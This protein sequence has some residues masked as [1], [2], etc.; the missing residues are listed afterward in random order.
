MFGWTLTAPVE[1][2]PNLLA[3]WHVWFH[4]HTEGTQ[5]LRSKEKR[6]QLINKSAEN[7]F[8]WPT[9]KWT[10]VSSFIDQL[11]TLFSH[12]WIISLLT[13][14]VLGSASTGQG[15]HPRHCHHF[16]SFFLALNTFR[17]VL[18][19][20]WS[21]NWQVSGGSEASSWS[22]SHKVSRSTPGYFPRMGYQ[23]T[24]GY[25]QHFVILPWK[26]PSSHLHFCQ[27]RSAVRVTYLANEHNIMTWPGLIPRPLD[28]ESSVLTIC[29]PLK[30]MI[31]W[32]I[33]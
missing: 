23:P 22:L 10:F 25:F 14:S 5:P 4:H 1:D 2:H 13:V 8:K 17:G 12:Q 11:I 19:T 28:L 30:F 7:I 9:T 20:P 6:T 15:L 16:L 27:E 26:F 24:A 29:P 31:T 3:T 18:T 33:S 32:W 21:I